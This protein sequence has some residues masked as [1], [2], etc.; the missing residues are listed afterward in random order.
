MARRAS[1]CSITGIYLATRS[2]RP[3][4]CANS[5][6]ARSVFTCSQLVSYWP[7]EAEGI[8]MSKNVF[9]I[10]AALC[11]LASSSAATPDEIVVI[12][13]KDNDIDELSLAQLEAI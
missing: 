8:S 11:A 12:V 10:A 2:A 13:N 5:L 7:S 4:P 6:G 9:V 1:R 3:S